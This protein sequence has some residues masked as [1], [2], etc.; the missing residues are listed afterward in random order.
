MVH[1]Q[2]MLQSSYPKVYNK[3][4]H[5][6][7]GPSIAFLKKLF[8]ETEVNTFLE[9]NSRRIGLD[10]IDAILEYLDISYT[11]NHKE[12]DNIPS[13]GK[14][15][16]IANHP[17]GAADALSLIQMLSNAR[18]DKKVKIVANPM[19]SHLSQLA[20]LLIPVD[21]LDGKL[22]RSSLEAIDIALANEELLI[23]FPAG[24]VSRASLN[25]IQDPY[26]K[27][28]FV[29]IAQRTQT[30]I[31]P[32]HI[33]ARNSSLFYILSMIYKP[34]S[35]L[36]LGHE[37][38]SSFSS[39]TLDFTIG[40]IIPLSSFENT[41]L[42]P[43]QYTK[44][45]KKHLYRIAKHKP[46]IFTTEQ[47]ISQPVQ[48]QALRAEIHK[49]EKLGLTRDGKEIYLL[50]PEL[51]PTVLKEI[52]R[53]REY[54]FRKVGEGTGTH[55][56]VD[57]YDEYYL[58]L[59]L[60]DEE[61]L[62]IVG[63]YRIGECAWIL[64]WLGKEGLYMDELCDIS[65]KLDKKLESAIELGRSFIQPKYWGTR[66]LDYLWQGLG[67][68]LSHNPQIKYMYGPVSISNTYPK[69]AKDLLVYFYMNYF[70]PKEKYIKAKRPY[71][72]SRNT[73]TEFDTLFRN[74][75]YTEAF[76]TLKSYLKGL[77]VSVPTLYKQ[78]G[79]L[80][81]EGGVEFFD[82]GIDPS[83]NNAIDGYLMVDVHKLKMEKRQKYITQS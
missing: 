69:L 64:S 37:L 60:W 54:T 49:G 67:A 34:L 55:N 29:K 50:D 21:N 80:F 40:S 75:D 68:Y 43:K 78:Y 12:L 7:L 4:P 30:P 35:S 36:L 3:V 11:T 56:D 38:F 65:D 26:W 72:L 2:H 28:G 17:L 44:L 15:I 76:F 42:K 70:T 39:K 1:V 57:K 9:N 71:I 18:Q 23:F 25:G 59:I 83:F 46:G 63:A 73:R 82:F 8:H 58:H 81:E 20:P 10:F 6:F 41:S 77:G 22:S 24:E 52:G 19:L 33:N 61:E 16:V 74:Q 31:L 51:S 13:I 5:I 45:F 47:S 14:T 66:A 32:I 53:L 27:S 62:E 79:D 48:R